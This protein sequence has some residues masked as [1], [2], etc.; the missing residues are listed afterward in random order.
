MRR[1]WSEAFQG[2]PFDLK[3]ISSF[4]FRPNVRRAK[5]SIPSPLRT[6]WRGLPVFDRVTM[7]PLGTRIEV[8]D[9]EP[10]EFAV[11]TPRSQR[12]TC[13]VSKLIGST[14]SQEFAESLALSK[15]ELEEHQLRGMALRASTPGRTKLAP[16]EMHSS[17]Q[18]SALSGCGLRSIASRE[19]H[20][21]RRDRPFLPRVRWLRLSC[22]RTRGALRDQCASAGSGWWLGEIA[23]LI[24]ALEGYEPQRSFDPRRGLASRG[25]VAR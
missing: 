23:Q 4:D 19:Q 20:Q 25:G 13:E 18:P 3:K 7:H 24:Q 5:S 12:A 22:E 21:G 2:V 9:A 10:D 17:G 15:T 14:C 1:S 8:I 11:T 6:T 16:P